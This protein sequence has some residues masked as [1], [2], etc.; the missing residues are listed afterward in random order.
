[1]ISVIGFESDYGLLSTK[2]LSQLATKMGRN[3]DISF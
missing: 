2:P 1:M 3:A